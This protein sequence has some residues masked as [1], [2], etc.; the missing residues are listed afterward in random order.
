MLFSFGIPVKVLGS[1]NGYQTVGICEFG[2][3]AYFIVTLKL[4]ADRHA[5]YQISDQMDLYIYFDRVIAKICQ[6]LLNVLQLKPQLWQR[7]C[8]TSETG[9]KRHQ[10][11]RRTGNCALL[12]I[13]GRRVSALSRPPTG[14][15]HK[16]VATTTQKSPRSVS[17]GLSK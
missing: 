15:T 12:L 3:H 4:C 9:V 5:C 17:W 6:G 16:P 13:T 14:F 2:K 1:S 11:V 10:I 7:A 8:A